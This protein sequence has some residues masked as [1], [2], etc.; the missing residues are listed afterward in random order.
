MAEQFIV[1]ERH[2]GDSTALA[3]QC[4]KLSME[5]YTVKSTWPRFEIWKNPNNDTLVV[6]TFVTIL[7]SRTKP[8]SM[9]PT[10]SPQHGENH[11]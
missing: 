5:G 3:E 6:D 2:V 10:M 8:E 11:G 1:I 7:L 4:T 9:D